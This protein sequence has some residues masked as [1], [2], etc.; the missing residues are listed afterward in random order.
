MAFSMPF[1][2][3]WLLMVG[4]ACYLLGDHI[5]TFFKFVGGNL[6]YCMGVF[7]FFQGFGI[8]VDFLMYAKIVGILRTIFIITAVVMGLKLIVLLGIFDMWFN[9]RRFFRKDNSKGEKV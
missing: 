7:Y 2:S 3:V 8:L 5:G 6:L 1:H 4:M 9:F